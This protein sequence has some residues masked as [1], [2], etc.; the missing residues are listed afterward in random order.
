MQAGRLMADLV[1][2]PCE[3]SR[4]Q[5]NRAAQAS[6]SLM[7]DIPVTLK[8]ALGQEHVYLSAGDK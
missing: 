1:S 8:E 6:V 4:M 7:A 3:C 2:Q 5:I